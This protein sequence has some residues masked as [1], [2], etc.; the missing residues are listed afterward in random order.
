MKEFKLTFQEKKNFCVCSVLQAILRKYNINLSQ[1][2]ISK[3]LT[4]S[5]EGGYFIDDGNVGNFLFSKGFRYEHYFWNTTPFHEPDSLLEEMNQNEGMIGFN[6]HVY[7]LKNFQDPEL[8][9]IDPKDGE[10]IKKNLHDL[11]KDMKEKE[12]IFGL[13]KKVN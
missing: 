11:L 10:I 1:K 3:N 6:K 7:I 8:E 13:I 2:E 5:K 12:G 4:P 9:I